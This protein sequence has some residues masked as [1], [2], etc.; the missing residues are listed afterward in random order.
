MP[1]TVPTET[2]TSDRIIADTPECAS[3]HF[4]PWMIDEQWFRSAVE[5]VKSGAMRPRADYGGDS[6]PV[7]L[8]YVNAGGVAVI[9]LAGPLMKRASKFGGSSSV[10]I[11]SA[12]R[13][14]IQDDSIHSIL[15]HVDSPGGTVAGTADLAAD[16]RNANQRK[17]V[18]AHIEDLGASAAYWVASQARRVTA[19]PTALIGSI[20]TMIRLTDESG[21]YAADGIKVHVVA[22]G[23]YKG[24]G[25]EGAPITDEHLKMFQEEVN[26][27]NEH[28]VKGVSEGRGMARARV[29]ALADGR[30]HISS[31]AKEVG[32]IDEVRSLDEVFSFITAERDA[33]TSQKTETSA[34]EVS[35]RGE[36]AVAQSQEKPTMADPTPSI[37]PTA[38]PLAA[39]NQVS[40]SNPTADLT[41]QAI[42]GY[43]NKGRALGK[44]EG[45]RAAVD[46][47]RAIVA[48]APGRADIAANAF[49]AGQNAATVALIF[50]ADAKARQE[51]YA[52]KQRLEQEI[53][54]LHAYGA[55]ASGGH[56]GVSFSPSHGEASIPD[57]IEPEARANMEY[58]SDPMI[59]AQNPDKNKW[60]LYRTNQLK[61]SV[62]VLSR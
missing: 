30:V 17:P 37:V 32:L 16:V 5:A 28:F 41:H 44:T 45:Y 12:I 50:D 52:E 33:A 3:Q 40:A 35:P 31:K 25:A 47:F 2:W 23:K 27:L 49:L 14:A 39:V 21:K 7:S 18:Y 24:A 55:G 26:D 60:I 58:E 56:V 38:Q 8:G 36:T 22:T 59:R 20:G 13:K 9:P 51:A 11:R 61:G 54:K 29:E 57:S 10:E 6:R 15:L 43:I 19:N 34:T 1:E 62:R 53:A 42:E 4:A 48:S 46:D